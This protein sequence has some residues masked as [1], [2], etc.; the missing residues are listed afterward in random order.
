MLTIDLLAACVAIC[1]RC[2]TPNGEFSCQC[3]FSRSKPVSDS[4]YQPRVELFAPVSNAQLKL[5]NL[6]NYYQGPTEL[7]DSQ[8]MFH[9]IRNCEKRLK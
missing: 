1:A 7:T 5:G 9:W 3:I 2:E 4:M 8:I 6:G